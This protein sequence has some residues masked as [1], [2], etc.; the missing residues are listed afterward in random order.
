MNALTSGM[1]IMEIAKIATITK[2]MSVITVTAN[3]KLK[4]QLKKASWLMKI[5]FL[6]I[7]IA[8]T[9]SKMLKLKKQ[10]IT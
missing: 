5:F 1:T 2:P 10:K 4:K 3:G 9:P 8:L 6:I 7:T